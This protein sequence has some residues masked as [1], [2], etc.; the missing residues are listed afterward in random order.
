MEQALRQSIIRTLCYFDQFSH[1]LTAW[2]LYHFLWQPPRSFSY[3]DFVNQLDN[4]P[5]QAWEKTNGYYHCSRR[6]S[7]VE[8]RRRRLLWT[9]K[10]M[11]IARRATRVISFIPFVEAIFV[12]NTVAAGWPSKESDIDV[13]IIIREGRLWFTRF[14]ITGFIS[15]ANLRRRGQQVTDCICLSFYVTNK[16]L[17]ITSIR[18]TEP[19]IY[20]V[21]WIHQLV[22]VYDPKNISTQFLRDNEWTR[23]YVPFCPFE[24]EA[25]SESLVKNSYV[26]QKMKEMITWFWSG[27]CGNWLEQWA[28]VWQRQRIDRQ[29][30]APEPA[31][32]VSDTMLKFHE[33]DRRLSYQE[34]WQARSH[35]L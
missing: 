26:M 2:E 34:E 23:E 3:I 29:H 19:D 16:H 6:A 4:Y 10:K 20:L 27:Q 8:I 13:F 35:R 17:T 25:L 7:I 33:E 15:I 22:P 24:K 5:D 9:E 12:C 30:H 21:Y 28:R 14:L 11:S 31:V 1:P 18:I 32:V